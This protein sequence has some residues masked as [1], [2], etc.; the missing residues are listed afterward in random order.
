M[1]RRV[2]GVDTHCTI[3]GSLLYLRVGNRLMRS[4]LDPDL[5]PLKR[6]EFAFYAMFVTEAWY[7]DLKERDEAAKDDDEE[8][9]ADIRHE[10]VAMIC[11]EKNC[12]EKGAL[13]VLQEEKK[14][15]AEKKKAERKLAAK[16]AR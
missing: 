4:Y 16:K 6:I 3:R 10:V 15:Q 14:E 8:L 7:A 9:A 5:D 12:T 2:V 11:A 13:K 1:Q